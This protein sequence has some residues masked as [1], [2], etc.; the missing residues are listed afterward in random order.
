MLLISM[1][2]GFLKNVNVKNAKLFMINKRAWEGV[3]ER[4]TIHIFYG[5]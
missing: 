4:S 2:C 1:V 3:L 5:R